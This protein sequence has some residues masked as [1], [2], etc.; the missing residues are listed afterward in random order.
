[1]PRPVR[2]LVWSDVTEPNRSVPYHHV[3]AE[4]PFG[5]FLI[6]WKGWKDNDFPTID[7]TPWH[8]WSGVGTSVEDAK[9]MAEAEYKK[10]VLACLQTEETSNAKRT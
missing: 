3:I 6:T 9:A 2:P 1:M 7:E 5:R 10:R 4:T 8:E